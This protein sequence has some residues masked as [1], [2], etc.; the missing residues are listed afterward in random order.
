MNWISKLVIVLLLFNGV[1]SLVPVKSSAED[2]PAAV[3]MGRYILQESKVWFVYNK[4]VQQLRNEEYDVEGDPDW[5]LQVNYTRSPNYTLKCTI[6]KLSWPNVTLQNIEGKYDLNVTAHRIM[7]DGSIGEKLGSFIKTNIPAHMGNRWE[8]W[9]PYFGVA[10]NPSEFVIGNSF[11]LRHFD[12]TVNR[13]EILA[14]TPWGQ[15]LTYVL[16]GTNVNETHSFRTT[17]WCDGNSG[18]LLKQ[19]WETNVPTHL[20]HEELRTIETGAM[21]N[22]FEVVREGQV[23]AIPINTNSTINEFIFDTSTNRI[24]VIINGSTG[25]LGMF[26]ITIPKSLVPT[27]YDVEVYIDNKKTNYQITEDASNY[28]VYLEYYHSEHTITINFAAK[29][30]WMQWWFF[31]TIGVAIAVIV[32]A[33]Y[34]L[35]KRKSAGLAIPQTP[36]TTS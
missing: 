1:F 34:L 33:A 36:S 15:N 11:T 16:Y 25:T 9:N 28:Y 6:A 19:T 8:S 4:T 30:I 14:D 32:G 24:N 2:C 35:I 31:L 13:T 12:Y 5:L 3:V 27:G 23:Y 20:H 21:R 17:L 10:V 22:E 29:P 18:I 7:E 26:N